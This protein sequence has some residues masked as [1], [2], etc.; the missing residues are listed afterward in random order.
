M[1][2]AR[3][4]R[5]HEPRLVYPLE[6]TTDDLWPTCTPHGCRP[7]LQ[8][9]D[10]RELRMFSREGREHELGYRLVALAQRWSL[11]LQDM[12]IATERPVSEV[13]HIITT[14]QR[15]EQM[16]RENEVADRIRRHA[17]AFV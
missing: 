11:S 14:F 8:A 3:V 15:H 6:M 16:C 9:E 4:R 12:V 1:V 13:M 7:D 2:R 17:L 5:N 10:M